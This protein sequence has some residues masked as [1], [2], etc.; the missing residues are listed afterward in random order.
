MKV[1]CFSPFFLQNWHKAGLS[2]KCLMWLYKKSISIPLPSFNDGSY[3]KKFKW[4]QKWPS[5]VAIVDAARSH[6]HPPSIKP[7]ADLFQC[8][9]WN[10]NIP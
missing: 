7:T 2:C 3:V 9:K 6:A 1:T 4:N 10:S 8:L 5:Q